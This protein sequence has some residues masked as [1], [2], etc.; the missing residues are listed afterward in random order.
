MCALPLLGGYGQTAPYTANG[1][2]TGGDRPHSCGT[3]PELA[4]WGG[5]TGLR[6]GGA[7][8]GRRSSTL[9]GNAYGNP[10][11]RAVLVV[12]VKDG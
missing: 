1:L 3:A 6:L 11:K 9:S 5:G 2:A 4:S 7:A 10:V 12:W 8:R